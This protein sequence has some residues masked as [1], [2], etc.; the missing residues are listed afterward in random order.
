MRSTNRERSN[1]W[2]KVKFQQRQKFVIGGFTEDAN[3]VDAMVV[4][5]YQG[6]RLLSAAKVRAGLDAGTASRLESVAVP[7]PYE[8]VPVQQSA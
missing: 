4:G 5:Y 7:T 6:K 3:R 1:T 2:L 8:V